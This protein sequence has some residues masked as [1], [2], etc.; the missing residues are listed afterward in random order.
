VL[1][2]GYKIGVAILLQS[3]MP[4]FAMKIPISRE[5]LILGVVA[6]K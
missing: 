3:I 2:L 1:T 6:Q 4:N 5:L